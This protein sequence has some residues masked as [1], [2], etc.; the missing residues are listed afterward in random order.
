[1]SYP[2]YTNQNVATSNSTF[3]ITLPPPT[4]PEPQSAL[5][6]LQFRLQNGRLWWFGNQISSLRYWLWMLI[7]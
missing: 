4:P 6:R 3:T 7:R 2:I 1:M 5:S